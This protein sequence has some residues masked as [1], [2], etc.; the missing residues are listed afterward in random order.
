MKKN[1]IILLSVISLFA[2]NITAQH[3]PLTFGIKAGTNLSN[4]GGDG[5]DG[6]DA[7]FGYNFG[8][9][10][11]Y[12]IT[13][14][15]FLA[16]GIEFTNKGAKSELSESLSSGDLVYDFKLKQT[17]TA[18]YLQLPIHA[19]Y[20]FNISKAIKLN[21]HAGPYFAFGIAGKTK[22]KLSGNDLGKALVM[23]EAGEYNPEIDTFSDDA[24]KRFDLGLGLGAGI[25]YEAFNVGLGYD[26]GLLNVSHTEGDDYD[27]RT[28]NA[29]LAIGYKFLAK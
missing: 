7:K 16:S 9:T 20:K 19:G 13:D 21:F 18:N 5:M 1:K 8:I 15:F 14:N 17:A 4:L 10:V 25:E 23:D 2:L 3:R 29:Y 26:F 6:S 22:T 28:Q 27:I 12:S 11:D 24:L